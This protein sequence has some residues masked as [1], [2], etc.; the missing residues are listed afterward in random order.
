MDFYNF[1]LQNLPNEPTEDSVK[2]QMKNAR[3][4]INYFLPVDKVPESRE[5]FFN[6]LLGIAA[7]NTTS[8]NIKEKIIE[9]IDNFFQTEQQNQLAV[10][11]LEKGQAFVQDAQQTPIMA[12]TLSQKRNILKGVC[13]QSSIQQDAKLSLL[14]QVL[15][16]D[17]SDE[18]VGTHMHC[19]AAMP[20]PE[21]KK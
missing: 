20:D 4:L 18:S 12:L 7:K 11:W 19:L 8:L 3:G 2:D 13:G 1:L 16:D 10:Q 15:G 21:S 5:K 9:G 17:K 6:A 14:Q